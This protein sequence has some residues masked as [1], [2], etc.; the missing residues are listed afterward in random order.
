L[1]ISILCVISQE[2]QVFS[3]FNYIGVQQQ[4]QGIAAMRNKGAKIPKE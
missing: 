4:A 3:Y 1:I 2:K